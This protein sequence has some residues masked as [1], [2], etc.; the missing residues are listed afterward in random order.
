MLAG[1]KAR[2]SCRKQREKVV[3]FQ[4]ALWKG[5]GGIAA[6]ILLSM[7]AALDLLFLGHGTL[8]KSLDGHT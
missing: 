6:M 5:S 2:E 7:E 1:V 3:G 4:V 8:D